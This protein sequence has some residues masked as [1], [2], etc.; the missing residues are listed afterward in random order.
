MPRRACI[1]SASTQH[2]KK[3]APRLYPAQSRGGV[4]T[5]AGECV[6][7]ACHEQGERGDPEDCEIA[8]HELGLCADVQPPPSARISCTLARSSR[9][10][11]LSESS[12]VCS[13][14]VCDVT[15]SR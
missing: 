14:T 4:D 7:C 9:V 2:F 10:S 3:N 13:V 11:R 6:S 8:T 15:T 5:A 12:C 1:T